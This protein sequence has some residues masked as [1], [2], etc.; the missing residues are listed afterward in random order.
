MTVQIRVKSG[1]GE[2]YDE[3]N[4]DFLVGE[5]KNPNFP[6]PRIGES[7]DILEPNDVGK[8]SKNG[9]VLKEYH[10]YL[11]TDVRYKVTNGD[12][13]SVNVYVVPIGRSIK[14]RE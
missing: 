3:C 14:I 5:F 7:I 11:V 10:Q 6:I 4:C 8:T 1:T 12:H 13:F 2:Y 9:G